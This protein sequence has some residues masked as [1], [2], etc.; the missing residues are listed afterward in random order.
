MTSPLHE[1][2]LDLDSLQELRSLGEA[3]GQ[4]LLSE[5][6]GLFVQDTEQQLVRLHQ[7]VATG[8]LLAVGQIVHKVK[9][10]SGQLGARQ[11]ASSCSRLERSVAAGMPVGALD[12]DVVEQ[13]Y[14]SLRAAL[15]EHASLVAPQLGGAS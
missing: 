5:V 2:T 12:L 9:G 13:D 10:G 6:I 4:D 7:A 3:V 14:Q 11:L 8:D 1:I 15:A